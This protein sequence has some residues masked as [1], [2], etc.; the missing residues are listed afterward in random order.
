MR[1]PESNVGTASLW[2]RWRRH[3]ATRVRQLERYRAFVQGGI[4][5]HYKPHLDG[6]GTTF[7]Q[8]FLPFLRSRGMPKQQRV[9]EWCAGPGFIGFAMLGDGLCESLC[10]ADVNTAAVVACERTVRANRLADRVSVYRSDN[11]ALIP[12]TEQWDLVVGSPPHHADLFARHA[13]RGDL[14]CFDGNWEIHRGFFRQVDRFLRPG[15]VIVL[16]ESNQGSTPETFQ[17][18]IEDAGFRIAFV[19]G[20]ELRRTCEPHFYFMGIVRAGD[21]P[22]AWAGVDGAREPS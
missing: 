9:F 12:P 18:M 21:T 11:L 13:S 16:Q 10:L 1:R 4:M 15:G 19:H 3:L 17:R 8:E 5:I 6:G 22:P 14:R 20:S 7:G 2:S